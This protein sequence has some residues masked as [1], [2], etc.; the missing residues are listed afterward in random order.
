MTPGTDMSVTAI[1]PGKKLVV[2]LQ[3]A[4]SRLAYLGIGVGFE[5]ADIAVV[6][7]C[8]LIGPETLETACAA[9]DVILTVAPALLVLEQDIVY[10]EI[11]DP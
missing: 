4:N 11:N 6:V 1:M 8:A 2:A 10:S 3:Y 7:S 9:T 5:A